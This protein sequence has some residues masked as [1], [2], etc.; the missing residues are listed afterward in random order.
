MLAT[1]C[2]ALAHEKSRMH[3]GPACSS[4]A[5]NVV[6]EASGLAKLKQGGEQGNNSE[7]DSAALMALAAAKAAEANTQLRC[8]QCCACS[9]ILV[10]L[11]CT[12]R[13]KSCSSWIVQ[14]CESAGCILSSMC[15]IVY[16]REAYSSTLMDLRM[17]GASCSCRHIQ[18][19]S[20]ESAHL[21]LSLN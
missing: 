16:C 9:G 13:P 3:C 7:A 19:K 18:C 12:S 11:Q 8:G 10:R 1:C 5:C 14:C 21:R 20:C 2:R 15:R 17:C 6:Q 4:S